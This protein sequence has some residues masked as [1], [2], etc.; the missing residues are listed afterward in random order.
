ME[1]ERILM[2]EEDVR[3][4]M[5]KWLEMQRLH[6]LYHVAEEDFRRWALAMG[7]QYGAPEG[8]FLGN[9]QDGFLKKVE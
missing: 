4:G 7:R 6:A 8:Y 1:A 2:D 5:A 9:P 3:A